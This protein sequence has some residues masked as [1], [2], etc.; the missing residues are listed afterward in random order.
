M[1]LHKFIQQ[2]LLDNEMVIVPGFG[3]FIQEYQPAEISEDSDEIKPPST[4]LIFNAQIRNND[5]LLVG[6]LAE[7]TRDSHFEALQKIEKERDNW[8][9]QLD[10]GEKVKLEGIGTFSTNE[11][12]EL[13]FISEED[14]QHSLE[15][16]GLESTSLHETE[17][18]EPVEEIGEVA[19]E[20][21][22]T[23]EPEVEPEII[24]AVTSEPET[25][26]IQ[27]EEP[28][29]T[30][31]TESENEEIQE[32]IAPVIEAEQEETVETQEEKIP[33][34]APVVTSEPAKEK[35]KGGSWWLLLILIPLIG[36]AVFLFMKEK[37]PAVPATS[38]PPV[39]TTVQEEAPAIITDSIQADST[40]STANDSL[41]VPETKAEKT[42]LTDTTGFFLVG[43]SF[44]EEE[45][46][47]TYLQQ[48][49]DDGYQPFHLGKYGTYYIVGIGRYNTEREALKARDEYTATN[50]NSGVWVLEK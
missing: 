40:I 39:E 47:E 5:G 48:L 3:A 14:Q 2:L 42:A 20:P 4:R 10:K 8:L 9:Y 26:E 32:E 19:S 11:K 21:E 24:P 31:E 17:E 37:Q 50:P 38:T 45:N 13:V 25:E 23:N 41:T 18:T 30:E 49:K 6:H 35:R 36:V 43:G 34:P 29:E 1:K 12:G 16:Y 33:E 27:E 7:N 46:A 22:Q 44:K 15:S 28:A